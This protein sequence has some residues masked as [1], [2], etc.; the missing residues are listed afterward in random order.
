MKQYYDKLLFVLALVVLCAGVAYVALQP[1]GEPPSAAALK[2]EQPKG[3]AFTAAKPEAMTFDTADW[4]AAVDQGAQ[5]DGLWVYGV[6]TPPKIWW[7]EETK[8]F[9]ATPPVPPKVR[10][11]FGVEF[12]G[13]ELKPYRVQLTGSID[14]PDGTV[15]MFEEDGVPGT[16]RLRKGETAKGQEVEF[17]LEDTKIVR[18]QK[19]DGTL[20]RRLV[21]TIKDLKTGKTLELNDKERLFLTDERM[22][23]LRAIKEPSQV[24]KFKE[25]PASFEYNGGTFKIEE[26][27]FDT[28]AIK[29]EKVLPD[30]K[31]S[32]VVVL[33][34]SAATEPSA[35]P[36][37]SE[38]STT[39][40]PSTQGGLP[41][42]LFN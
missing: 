10:P 23:T 33:T 8:Q 4:S 29:V 19:E 7:N 1:S 26:I 25:A 24:W 5:K 34:P 42:D 32:E 17:T 40:T 41:A 37:P 21:A 30:F 31:E 35:S 15:L 27:N 13:V 9:E 12:V 39:E 14:M 38:K 2:T 36:E 11:P 3:A 16:M 20:E 6:F 18:Q 28:P 22:I